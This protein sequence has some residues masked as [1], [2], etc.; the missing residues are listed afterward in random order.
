M[1]MKGFKK[2]NPSSQD[3]ANLG[4]VSRTTVSAYINKTRFVSEELGN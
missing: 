1:Y 4:G 2:K 3:V